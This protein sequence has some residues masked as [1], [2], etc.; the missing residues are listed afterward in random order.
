M[1]PFEKLKE[2]FILISTFAVIYWFQL[3]D[4]KKRCKKREGIYDI[5]KLPLLAT[6]IVGLILFWE[7]ES[8]LAIFITQENCNNNLENKILNLPQINKL[9]IDEI[10]IK[11]ISEFNPIKNDLDVYTELPEW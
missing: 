11:R 3:V 7:K 8:F 4:D 5:I 6:A 1:L 2:F 10:N 9:P